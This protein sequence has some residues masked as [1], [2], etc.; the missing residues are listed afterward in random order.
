MV[1]ASGGGGLDTPPWLQIPVQ[2]ARPPD[3][4]MP[5]AP[6]KTPAPSTPPAQPRRAWWTRSGRTMP[7]SPQAGGPSGEAGGSARRLWAAEDSAHPLR[8]ASAA[9]ATA[10]CSPFLLPSSSA[11][12]STS[13]WG[14][15]LPAHLLEDIVRL[16]A[17]RCGREG[18]DYAVSRVFLFLFF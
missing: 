14:E 12:P 17:D 15:G 3:G 18:G 5:P 8:P 2:T 10:P 9:A 4:R 6:I 1:D 16:L 7:A 11:Q 13:D